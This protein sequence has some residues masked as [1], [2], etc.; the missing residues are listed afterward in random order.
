MPIYPAIALGYLLSEQAVQTTATQY[1]PWSI[2]TA[3][4]GNIRAIWS[5]LFNSIVNNKTIHN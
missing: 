3:I 2:H 4:A 1:R 5:P